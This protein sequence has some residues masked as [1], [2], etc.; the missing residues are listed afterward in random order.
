MSRHFTAVVT[1]STRNSIEWKF[2]IR[3]SVIFYFLSSASTTRHGT[4][5]SELSYAFRRSAPERPSLP[6]QKIEEA[7]QKT[8]EEAEE[9]GN[10]D[11]SSTGN[12]DRD[13]GSDSSTVEETRDEVKTR[14]FYERFSESRKR[15][16]VGIVAYAALLAP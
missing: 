1:D 6:G 3:Y 7:G 8:I 2:Q 14:A 13:K 11:T 16:I 9:T 15:G 10:T 5:S 4:M 12:N